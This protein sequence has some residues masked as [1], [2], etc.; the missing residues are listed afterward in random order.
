MISDKTQNPQGWEIA[1]ASWGDRKQKFIIWLS[2]SFII[3]SLPL[4]T[5]SLVRL[6]FRDI[7]F[8]TVFRVND[9]MFFTI[10]LCTTTMLSIFS[11]RARTERR[12]LRTIPLIIILILAAFMLGI[13]SFSDVF[14]NTATLYLDKSMLT[15]ASFILAVITIIFTLSIQIRSW[16]LSFERQPG[17]NKDVNKQEVSH[18]QKEKSKKGS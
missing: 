1:N 9:L 4:I 6:F 15:G 16:L 17:T 5:N 2:T 7:N 8:N 13:S 10:T 11:Q 3:G 18:E 12:I 14:P